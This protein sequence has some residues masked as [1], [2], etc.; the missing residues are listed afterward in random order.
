[1]NHE[2][3]IHDKNTR[4]LL[5]VFGAVFAMVALSFASVPLY[6][7]FCRVTGFG[8]T[9]QLSTSKPNT[10][11]DRD[12][13]VQFTTDVNSKLPW[14][15]KA[16]Q[17]EI[18]LKVGQDALASFTATNNG[19][20]PVSGTAIYNVTP[21]KVGQYFHKTQ[22]F[23]FINQTLTPNQTMNMPVVFYIDPAIA[24][25]PNLDD[26]ERITLS[27]SFFKSNTSDLDQA[28]EKLYNTP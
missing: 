19:S 6:D 2:K 26:V 25:D 15:F 27:Y 7:L 24:D 14:N 3:Q 20:E 17:H 9:P 13:T 8:G 12:I 21:A 1:M 4:T 22:C 18:T 10:I 16:D 28:T 11:L 23:C 5:S